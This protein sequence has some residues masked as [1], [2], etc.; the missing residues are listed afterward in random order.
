MCAPQPACSVASQLR[1]WP[2]APHTFS[3][4]CSPLRRPTAPAHLQHFCEQHG[5]VLELAE[6]WTEV[7]VVMAKFIAWVADNMPGLHY[8]Q[9]K[10]SMVM[11]SPTISTSLDTLRQP[12]PPPCALHLTPLPIHP[13]QPALRHAVV[14]AVARRPQCGCAQIQPA[15]PHQGLV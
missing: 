6:G 9:K 14:W 8:P 11:P 7:V 12:M 4:H 5:F 15:V 1:S 2:P 3:P 10:A 13:P